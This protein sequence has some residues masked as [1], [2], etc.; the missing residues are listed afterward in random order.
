MRSRGG[1]Q[2]KEPLGGADLAADGGGAADCEFCG[3]VAGRL[4]ARV[5][6][7]DDDLVV[8]DNQLTWAPVM[9][10]I[11]PKRHMTQAEMWSSGDLLARIGSLAVRLGE[12]HCPNGFRVLSNFGMEALQTQLH[13]HVHVIGGTPLGFYARVRG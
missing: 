5:R 8:F 3:I 11:V 1:R 9:L 13:G 12:E 6:Y 10:L 2:A 7:S 4:P